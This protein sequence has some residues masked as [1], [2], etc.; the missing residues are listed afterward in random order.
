MSWGRGTLELHLKDENAVLGDT[1]TLS[2]PC[3]KIDL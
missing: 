2:V 3:G 1:F